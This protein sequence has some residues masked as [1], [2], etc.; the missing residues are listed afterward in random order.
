MTTVIDLFAGAGG[1]SE[2][3][4]MAGATPLWASNHWPTAV[5]AHSA[6]HPGTAHVCQDLRQAD[7]TQVP[8]HDVL[9]A[10]PACQGHSTASQPRRR[11]YHDAMR[12][13]AWAVV[14]AVEVCGP[15]AFAVENV[16]SFTR[17]ALFDHWVSSFE[18]LGYDVQTAL[19]T[20]SHFGVPQR[21]KRLFVVGHRCGTTRPSL[22][23]AQGV[24]PGYGAYL[25]ASAQGWKPVRS[26]PAGV[27]TRVAAGRRRH[28]SRFLTQ[29]VTGH[30]G[31]SLDEPIRTL[32]TASSHWN[33]VDGKRY[34]PLSLVELK[35]AMGFRDDYPLPCSS[36]ADAVRL[37]GN[38]VCPPVA[39]AIVD[40]L[41]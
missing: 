22:D 10:S 34:R 29:H 39:A 37:L 7:W 12:A 24:E 26:A 11:R 2:G 14:D 28:G 19:L 9:L 16:P 36:R 8:E 41:A 18:L 23:F 30:S 3:A 32:T 25:E 15:R 31:V 5:A 20:A 4:R 1:F 38:A 21:R 33:L 27:Q 17:W 13:T 6:A 35:R 40:R